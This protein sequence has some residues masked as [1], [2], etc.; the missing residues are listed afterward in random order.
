[1]HDSSNDITGLIKI[2][3]H[4][5]FVWHRLPMT[6]ERWIERRP[7]HCAACMEELDRVTG[8]TV[9]FVEPR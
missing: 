3:D 7:D 9:R 1:M 8:G 6:S 5:L 4:C 2:N